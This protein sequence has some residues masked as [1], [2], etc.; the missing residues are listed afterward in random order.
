MPTEKAQA[1]TAKITSPSI[2]AAAGPEVKH[3]RTNIPTLGSI[4][5]IR[6]YFSDSAWSRNVAFLPYSNTPCL[7]TSNQLPPFSAAAPVDAATTE[8]IHL[9]PLKKSP[10]QFYHS[11]ER[12]SYLSINR[13]R[14]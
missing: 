5:Q 1:K 11:T 13:T 8:N 6:V 2:Y 10:I 12:P 4:Q 9:Q 7:H 14:F 3:R